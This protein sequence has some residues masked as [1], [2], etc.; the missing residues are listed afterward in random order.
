M[1]GE[2]E[3]RRGVID[4]VAADDDEEVDQ[5]CLH[6]C[7]QLAQRRHVIDR[8]RLDGIGVEDGGADVTQ[9]M[10]HGMRQGVHDGR[11]LLASD[12]D[13]GTPMILQILTTALSH[14]LWAILRERQALQGL[15][16]HVNTPGLGR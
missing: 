1:L 6:V 14:W 16:A 3:I 7:H 10:I 12:D 8:P 5:A 15:S 4:R 9:G 11:L 13:A 2:A